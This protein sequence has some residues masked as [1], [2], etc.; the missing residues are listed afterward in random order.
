MVRDF[1]VFN[2]IPK[3]LREFTGSPDTFKAK[4]DSYLG[5]VPDKPALPHYSQQAA[6]NGLREQLAQQ[7]RNN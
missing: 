4:L 7:R 5:T 2:E 6:G 3:D 1:S